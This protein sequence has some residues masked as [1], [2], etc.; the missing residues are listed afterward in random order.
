MISIVSYLFEAT[1][2]GKEFE[3]SGW[4]RKNKLYSRMTTNPVFKE[5]SSKRIDLPTG[6]D[7]HTQSIIARRA[8]TFNQFGH[9]GS[10]MSV[11]ESQYNKEHRPKVA[12]NLRKAKDVT[13]PGRIARVL[14]PFPNKPR[15]ET[16]QDIKEKHRRMSISKPAGEL[17]S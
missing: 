10:K 3:K 15:P 17:P 9:S 12:E 2:F 11:G 1:R 16:K 6:T 7:T 14:N 8:N 5:L 13:V 4:D